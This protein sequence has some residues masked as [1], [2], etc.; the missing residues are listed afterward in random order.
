MKNNTTIALVLLLLLVCYI[1]GFCIGFHFA[2]AK[3]SDAIE[4]DTILVKETVPEYRPMPSDTV[5]VEVPA[6][7]DTAAVVS[8][9]YAKVVY[10]DKV[11]V[12][13]YGTVT[14]I[15]TVYQNGIDNR[16]IEY[17][18][19]FP[20]YTKK[21][22]FSFSAG[23]FVY[24]SGFGPL[25]GARYKHLRISAGYDLKNKGPIGALQYEF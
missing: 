2:K 10:V 5:Y 19:S 8:A 14:I 4:R 23:A 3:Y 7:I 25:L 13:S 15:D 17:D 22:K 18:L 24:G 21:K 1:A 20:T 16:V 11:P 12:E 9:Y 6:D